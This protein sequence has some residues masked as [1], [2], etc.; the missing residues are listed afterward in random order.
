MPLKAGFEGK[1]DRGTGLH[2]GT[3]VERQLALQLR[4]I[5]KRF[6]PV[7]ANHRVDLDVYRGEILSILGE[8]GRETIFGEARSMKYPSSSSFGR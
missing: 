6:G 8:N 4:G 3:A 7:V 5:T 2:G 1:R